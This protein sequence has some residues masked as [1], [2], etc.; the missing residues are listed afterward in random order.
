MKVAE[1]YVLWANG[2]I[3]GCKDCEFVSVFLFAMTILEH[4]F[5]LYGA[6][7]T[8]SSLK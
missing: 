4:K 1:I 5:E 3:N 8:Y 7:S 6:P 2:R